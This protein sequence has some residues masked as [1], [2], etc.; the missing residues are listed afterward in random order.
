MANQSS[1]KINWKWLIIGLLISL[2]NPYF[3]GIILGIALWSEPNTKLEGKI[4]VGFSIIWTLSHAFL[5]RHQGFK[6]PI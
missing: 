4:I 2:A 5:V 1:F 3:A 6:L